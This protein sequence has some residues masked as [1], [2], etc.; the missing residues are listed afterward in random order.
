MRRLPDRG[1]SAIVRREP[2]RASRSM[3]FLARRL[4]RMASRLTIRRRLL[5]AHRKLRELRM[6]AKGLVSTR[7]PL[8]AHIIPMRRCNLA[9]TYCNEYRRFLRSPSRPRRCFAASTGWPAFG[10]AIIT[11]SGGEPLLHPELDDI[12]RA[13]PPPRHDRRPDHQRLPADRRTRIERLNRAGLDY[14]QISIDNVKPDDVSKKSLKVLD[15]KLELLAEH[16]EFHVNIN[17][18]LGSGVSNPEDALTVAPPRHRI[19]A[20]PARWDHPRWRRAASAAGRRESGNFRRDHGLGKRALRALQPL[21]GQY[22][23]RASPTTGAA[24]P[25]RATS[26]SART[27]WCTTARSSAAIPA[28]RSRIHRRAAPPRVFHEEGLRAALHRFLRAA[29]RRAGQ[30]ARSAD[31]KARRGRALRACAGFRIQPPPVVI[32]GEVAAANASQ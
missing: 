12:I 29:G 9:C 11:I 28:F 24:A 21:P 20:S 26:T 14:L 19:W 18:V 2:R 27:A 30:L 1:V 6:I 10:T 7:H 3:G 16:A 31:V 23:R 13:H 5:A 8:L 17:S 15:Q 25:A 4:K 22:R 32:F